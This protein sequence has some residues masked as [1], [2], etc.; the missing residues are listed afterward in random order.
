MF[1]SWKSRCGACRTTSR[2]AARTGLRDV[3]LQRRAVFEA[4]VRILVVGGA[5]DG[6]LDR[7][8]MARHLPLPSTPTAHYFIERARRIAESLAMGV[9]GPNGAFLAK[10]NRYR[11]SAPA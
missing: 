11:S 4:H 2:R 5:D 9:A 3:H 10:G 7:T 1:A 6:S 8:P